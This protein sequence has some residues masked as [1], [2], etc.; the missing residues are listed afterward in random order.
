M[1]VVRISSKRDF[2]WH[3]TIKNGYL[4]VQYL[5]ISNETLKIVR[6]IRNQQNMFFNMSLFLLLVKCRS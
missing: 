1:Y 4:L 3:L 6:F 5:I 2:Q